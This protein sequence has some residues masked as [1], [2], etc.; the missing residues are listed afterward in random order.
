MYIQIVLNKMNRRF[1]NGSTWKQNNKETEH[2]GNRTTRN[3]TPRKQNNKKQNNME[4]EH[5]G[6]R[7]TWKQDKMET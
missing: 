7:T 1:G 2:Q 3:R 6:N 5:Q 4:T